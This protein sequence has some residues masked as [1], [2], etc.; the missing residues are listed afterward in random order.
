[1][2]ND[3][4]AL[5]Y[6]DLV[7]GYKAATTNAPIPRSTFIISCPHCNKLITVSDNGIQAVE[8][9]ELP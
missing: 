6:D 1:M 8:P 2:P 4:R 3:K 9:E 5:T 7:A